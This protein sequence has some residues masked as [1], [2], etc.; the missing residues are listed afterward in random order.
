MSG[1]SIYLNNTAV[2]AGPPY[3]SPLPR[4]QSRRFGHVLLLYQNDVAVPESG[5][6]HA[7]VRPLYDAAL[8]FTPEFVNIMQI[9]DKLFHSFPSCEVLQWFWQ[10]IP[11]SGIVRGR[12]I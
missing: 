6:D 12:D 10:D 9:L 3:R 7:V 5:I 11:F 2:S 4:P 1:G 8:P